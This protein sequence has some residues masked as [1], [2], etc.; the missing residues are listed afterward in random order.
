MDRIVTF[1]LLLV[2]AVLLVPGCIAEEQAAPEITEV[3]PD[4]NATEEGTDSALVYDF[5]ADINTTTLNMTL[6]QVALV[7]LPEN[8]T[9]GYM[10]NVTLS[11]GLE[12]GD[13]PNGTYVQ[14]AAPE[15]MVGV[16]GIHEWV[17]KAVETGE[18]TFSAIEKR[19]WE[20]ETGNE[21]TYTL[22]ILVE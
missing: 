3:A 20:E 22:N 8:P 5:T 15:G 9:T 13:D 2:A 10:W 11:A 4:M 19:E 16:G 7:Q 12:F 17:I 21:T 18:Q 14:D 6:D 1:L